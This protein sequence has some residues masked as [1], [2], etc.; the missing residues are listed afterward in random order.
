MKFCTKKWKF[1]LRIE[2]LYPGNKCCTQE[3]NFVPRHEILYPE[4]KICTQQW[5]FV[6]KS[7]VLGLYTYIVMMLI[8]MNLICNVSVF[9]YGVWVKW[10]SKKYFVFALKGPCIKR[11]VGFVCREREHF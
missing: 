8:E 4:M 6:F 2:I 5:N 1:E 3:I 10:M 11:H 7:L 9:M